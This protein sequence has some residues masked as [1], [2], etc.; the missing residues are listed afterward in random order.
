MSAP[1]YKSKINGNIGQ[2]LSP[3][4]LRP[5]L[6]GDLLRSAME[7]K[8]MNL[9]T[10]RALILSAV[11]LFLIASQQ[12]YAQ[13]SDNLTSPLATLEEFREARTLGEQAES[14]AEKAKYWRLAITWQSNHIEWLRLARKF[15]GD[16][17][18]EAPDPAD[19]RY[20]ESKTIYHEI[21]HRFSHMDFYERDGA[22]SY[23]S[24]S[25]AVPEAASVGLYDYPRFLDMMQDF[26]DR[27]VKDWLDEPVP[28]RRPESAFAF[29]P[30]HKRVTYEQRVA[31][32]LERRIRALEGRVFSPAETELIDA[33][34][35]Q[36]AYRCREDNDAYDPVPGLADLGIHYTA[37]TILA[38]V[39]K[40]VKIESPPYP[41]VRVPAGKTTELTIHEDLHDQ[42]HGHS[43]VDFDSGTV[44]ANPLQWSSRKQQST[45]MKRG[46]LDIAV[47]Y[48]FQDLMRI[49]AFNFELIEVPK[50][51]W[52]E[53][54]ASWEQLRA[55]EIKKGVLRSAYRDHGQMQYSI[56]ANAQL[57]ATFAFQTREGGMGLLQL[58]EMKQYGKNVREYKIRYRLNKPGKLDPYQG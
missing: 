29:E 6:I 18:N 32:W 14:F 33:A 51:F 17:R 35:R 23:W 24:D 3:R 50:S 10:H 11:S 44:C 8:M 43:K 2:L 20:K 39:H 45:W 12:A 49:I 19:H 53:Q 25:L 28:V 16:L 58:T 41:R 22:D 55:S 36:Y 31:D 42:V 9:A 52:N 30:R 4:S 26:H 46:G 15:A 21:L 47:D 57:P 54:P 1:L 5:A 27:R 56:L 38:A 13:S 34:V 37:P 40:F 7:R 48:H